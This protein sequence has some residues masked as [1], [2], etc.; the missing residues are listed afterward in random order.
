MGISYRSMAARLTRRPQQRI[1]GISPLQLPLAVTV[2]QPCR[3]ALQPLPW[4]LA[5]TTGGALLTQLLLQQLHR[6]APG[7]IGRGL[8]H[9]NLQQSIGAL[10]I[11]TGK[12]CRCSRQLLSR[13]RRSQKL[14]IRCHT[15]TPQGRFVR[16]QPIQSVHTR[17]QLHGRQ[18]RQ[19]AIHQTP[20]G[21]SRQ[22]PPPAT[23]GS[24]NGCVAPPFPG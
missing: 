2:I 6:Q 20:Q 9:R 8:L 21:Q 1:N 19:I 18:G 12:P 24:T 7:L 10:G 11:G 16:R 4:P 3:E 17:I 14:D 5:A 23:A 15:L 13:W 22:R